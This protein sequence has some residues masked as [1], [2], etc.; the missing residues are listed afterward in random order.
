MKSFTHIFRL[1]LASCACLIVTT[2]WSKTGAPNEKEFRIHSYRAYSD[3]N[4]W[5]DK[6]MIGIPNTHIPHNG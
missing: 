2:G 4:Y 3:A 5:N 1:L 6:L